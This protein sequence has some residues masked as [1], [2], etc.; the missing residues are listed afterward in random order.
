MPSRW[1]DGLEDLI[2]R[3][4]ER[5]AASR[6]SERHGLVT[7]YDAT[8]YLAKVMIQPEGFETGWL[9]IETGHV[10][11]GFGFAV[12]LTSGDGKTTG[13][14]VIVRFQE[15]D[16]E[17]GKIVQRVHSVKNPPPTVQSGEAVMWANQGSGG[18]Q[19]IMFNKAGEI[20]HQILNQ[21]GQVMSSITM[22]ETSITHATLNSSGTA[23]ASITLNG[24]NITHQAESAILHEAQTITHEASQL[25][26]LQ[27]SAGAIETVGKNFLGLTQSGQ[28][29]TTQ[30]LGIDGVK[31]QVFGLV[32]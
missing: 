4:I 15:G 21:A 20:L 26:S 1:P 24:S 17:S 25:L 10:G 6:F 32:G 8:N 22:N 13:D 28:R 18:Q 12:G 27:S 2:F 31:E 9:Q 23:L 14:Q 30:V 7:S 16:F 5:H 11:M 19:R 3:C 29:P